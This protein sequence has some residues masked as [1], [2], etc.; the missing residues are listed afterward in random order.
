MSGSWVNE[1]TGR[2]LNVPTSL[3]V[4]RGENTPGGQWSMFGYGRPK[5]QNVL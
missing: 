5:L 3:G 4:A 1:D 2:P